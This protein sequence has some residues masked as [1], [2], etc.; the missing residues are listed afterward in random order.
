MSAES[1]PSK[2][3]EKTAPPMQAAPI[4]GLFIA[5]HARADGL[6]IERFRAVIAEGA[7]RGARIC[8]FGTQDVD[9]G[10]GLV[11]YDFVD[12][13]V[14][15]TARSGIPPI[16]MSPTK[17]AGRTDADCI[18]WIRAHTMLTH[19]PVPSKSDVSELLI[20]S[21]VGEAVLPYQPLPAENP[22]PVLFDFL[23]RFGRVVLKP[24]G[25]GWS[26]QRVSFLARDGDRIA[27][28]SGVS[29]EHLSE[30][31]A[32]LRASRAAEITPHM[33][34]AFT[35]SRARGNR[36]FDIRVHTHKNG[37]G[38]WEIV[39]AYV[40]LSEE[41]LLVSNTDRGGYQGDLDHFFANAAPAETPLA[42]RVRALGLRASEVLEERLGYP[43]DE[44]GV[45]ILVNPD[46]RLWLAEINSR[47]VS[48]Y[49]EF[50]RA[51]L[52]V[53]YALYLHR[54]QTARGPLPAVRSAEGAS[55]T[56]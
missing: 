37:Q 53:D 25:N 5:R 18:A 15:R 32:V 54:T 22:G 48:R 33:I 43:L 19:G 23:E 49:H 42:D 36:T 51:R 31:E 50:K 14:V 46:Q 27:W 20:D 9:M 35:V 12:D 28:R 11:T 34:Q 47:P 3:L 52:A 44:L 56:E 2:D 39:R 55:A 41:G 10:S 24:A 26:G 38:R 29:L 8:W 7:M 13:G 6:E 30:G 45:D 17:A 16:V 40:R 4:L 1:T 21:P